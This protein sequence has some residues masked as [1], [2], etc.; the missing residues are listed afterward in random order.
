MMEALEALRVGRFGILKKT[1]EPTSPS[2]WNARQADQGLGAV[3]KQ[4]Y[5]SVAG[6]MDFHGQPELSS[7]M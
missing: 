4:V 7:R 1:Q 3:E 2:R 5:T 6:S